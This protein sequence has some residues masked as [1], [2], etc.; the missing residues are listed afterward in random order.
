MTMD[1]DWFFS[2]CFKPNH[3]IIDGRN[4]AM[5]EQEQAIQRH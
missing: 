2:E 1:G 5:E 3:K 4:R